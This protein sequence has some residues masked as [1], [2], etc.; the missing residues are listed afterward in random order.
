MSPLFS[1]YT[2]KIYLSCVRCAQSLSKRGL[3]SSQDNP[4][5]P[6]STF[7]WATF[8][9]TT[10]P[11]SDGRSLSYISL[12]DHSSHAAVYQTSVDVAYALH[13]YRSDEL[14]FSHLQIAK[15]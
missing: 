6:I 12:F 14:V 2:L 1:Q 8:D 7:Y 10:H 11:Q 5:T 9:K 3:L 13:T 4:M 15:A